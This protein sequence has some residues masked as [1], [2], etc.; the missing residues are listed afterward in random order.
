MQDAIGSRGEALFYTLITRFYGPSRPRF[1]P[2]FLGDKFATVDYLVELVDTGGITPFFF[3][4]VKTT[5]QGY[6]Q[7]SHRLKVQVAIEDIQRLIAYPAPTYI[8]G[9]DEQNET[10][11]INAILE[12]HSRRLANL[13]T[14]F[15]LNQTTLDQLWQEVFDFWTNRDMRFTASRFIN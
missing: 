14:A 15:P 12:G 6:T 3:V 11:Y 2:Q 9:I 1:R 5:R 8:V 13:S 4:Q 10:G 7:R